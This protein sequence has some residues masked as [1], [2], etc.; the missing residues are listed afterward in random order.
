MAIVSGADVV[1]V[2]ELLARFMID[3]ILDVPHFA[4]R[5]VYEAMAQTYVPLSTHSE[6]A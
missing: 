1:G 5:R 2:Q 4:D 3:A 6:Q